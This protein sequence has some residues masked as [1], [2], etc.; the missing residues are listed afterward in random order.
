MKLLIKILLGIALYLVFL[1]VYMPAN[2]LLSVAPL[3]NNVSLTGVTGTLWQGRAAQ[4]S[5]DKRSVEQVS[6]ELSPWGLLLGRA[7]IDF[8]IGNRNSLVNGRGYVSLSMSGIDAQ[9]LRFEAPSGFLLAGARL[10]F[11][12]RVNGDLSVVVE[13]FEQGKPWCEQLVGRAFINGLDVSNQFGNYP[14][15]NLNTGLSCED[16]QIKLTVDEAANALGLSG[17]VLLA[18]N[19]QVIVSAKIKPTDSQPDD[20]REALVFLGKQDSQ[21]Y[22]AINYRGRI[23]GM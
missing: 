13:N 20:L 23:P 16:G 3:P 21:G 19:N 6:W 5:F 15:G 12:T 9:D 4:V 7:N 18:E 14:L 17:T 2:W 22:Y 10:P 8:E 11:R 1:V